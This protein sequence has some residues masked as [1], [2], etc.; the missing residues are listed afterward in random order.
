[1]KIT[2]HLFTNKNPHAAPM[3]FQTSDWLKIM[4]AITRSLLHFVTV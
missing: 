2:S 3:C 1:M 4:S